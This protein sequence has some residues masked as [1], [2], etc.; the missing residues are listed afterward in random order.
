MAESETLTILNPKKNSKLWHS[1][2]RLSS[3]MNAQNCYSRLEEA[4]SY[5]IKVTWI[6]AKHTWWIYSEQQWKKQVHFSL[7]LPFGCQESF[8]EPRRLLALKHSRE[9][10]LVG[11]DFQI[12]EFHNIDMNRT[13]VNIPVWGE[14]S[15]TPS[16]CHLTSDWY[17]YQGKVFLWAPLRDKVE[18]GRC[19]Q[20]T[21]TSVGFSRMSC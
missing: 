15:S 17:F 18:G 2:C 4:T 20:C 11:E 21:G 6:A 5:S 12:Q 13:F 3:R 19:L 8:G 7:S 9:E 10:M 1:I 16:V 14:R